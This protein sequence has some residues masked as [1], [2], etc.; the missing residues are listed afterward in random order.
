MTEKRKYL[1]QKNIVAIGFDEVI[2][3]WDE[4]AQAY[5]PCQGISAFVRD[6][7]LLGYDLVLWTSRTGLALD[8]AKDVLRSMALYDYFCWKED[9]ED[10]IIRVIMP[11]GEEVIP[12]EGWSKLPA[13]M[14]IDPR[15]AFARDGDWDKITVKIQDRARRTEQIL[16]VENEKN[17]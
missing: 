4:T 8:N 17:L 14:Y 1:Q 3:D 7:F 13:L 6:L 15:C 9:F 11:L 5:Q 16:E 10:S 2:A 12:E